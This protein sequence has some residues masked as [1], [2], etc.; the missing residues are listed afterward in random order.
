[1]RLVHS[2][3]VL[4]RISFQ[5]SSFYNVKG[6]DY[7]VAR[8]KKALI[9]GFCAVLVCLCA[10]AVWKWS[11]KNY[12]DL[13]KEVMALPPSVTAEDL[14]K[15]GYL[16]LTEVQPHRL[17]EVANFFQSAHLGKQHLR[18]FTMTEDG[19]VVRILYRDSGQSFAVKMFVYNV[20]NCTSYV[21]TALYRARTSETALSDGT[22]EVWLLGG[23][24]TTPDSRSEDLAD[25]LL[26][27]Y[28]K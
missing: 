4:M 2:W 5:R 9:I 1:M 7:M 27:R 16:D 17:T 11:E 15:L 24:I 13:T 8:K 28:K 25:Y 19:P 6:A 12:E 26:Y 21:P 3:E 14:V 23:A 18:T 22:V 10:L 20:K